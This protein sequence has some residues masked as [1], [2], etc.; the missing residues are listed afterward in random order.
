MP[1]EQR[2]STGALVDWMAA[3]MRSRSRAVKPEVLS[4]FSL[5]GMVEGG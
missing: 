1:G 4:F 3:A 2:T 5:G